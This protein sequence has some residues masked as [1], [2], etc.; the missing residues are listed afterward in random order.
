MSA[1]DII[2]TLNIIINLGL[3]IKARFELLNQAAEEINLL[4]HQT[5]PFVQAL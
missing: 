3:D 4:K 1:L 5:S 2:S